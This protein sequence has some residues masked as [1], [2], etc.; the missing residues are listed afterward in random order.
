[1]KVTDEELNAKPDSYWGFKVTHRYPDGS[2]MRFVKLTERE[3]RQ[4]KLALVIPE[5]GEMY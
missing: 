1:M 5:D 3:S 4:K 2:P